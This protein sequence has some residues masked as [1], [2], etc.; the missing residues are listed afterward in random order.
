MI[1]E[2][3]PILIRVRGRLRLK[4][5]RVALNAQSLTNLDS[6]ILVD[7]TQEIIFVYHG[8]NANRMKQAKAIDIAS[9]IKNKEHGGRA[10]LYVIG[11]ST[12]SKQTSDDLFWKL[13]GSAPT[14]NR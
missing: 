12:P 2:R 5:K 10:K 7:P 9:R 6:F 4:S 1:Q 14:T 11:E 8:A 3:I 13:L